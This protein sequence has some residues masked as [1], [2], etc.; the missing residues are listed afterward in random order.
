M[1]ER[2]GDTRWYYYENKTANK[3]RDKLKKESS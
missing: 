2:D 3:E 1:R